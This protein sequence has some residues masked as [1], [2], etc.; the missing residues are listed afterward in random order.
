MSTTVKACWLKDSQGNKFAPKTLSS[1]V[2]TSD[3]VTLE[4]EIQ[5]KL[6]TK[7][8]TGHTHSWNNLQDKPFYE[9]EPVE[10]V[11]YEAEGVS[12]TNIYIENMSLIENET[13]T[14]VCNENTYTLV[15]KKDA[16]GSVYIGNTR[17]GNPYGEHTDTGENFYLSTYGDSGNLCFE[18]D[19]SYSIRITY[20]DTSIVELDKKYIPYVVGERVDNKNLIDKSYSEYV[21][22]VGAEIFNN[23]K[24]NIASGEY[25][26]AEGDETYAFG[27][28]S[29]AEGNHS[30]AEG[31]YSHAENSAHAEGNYSHAENS[32]TARGMCSHSEG[33]G[34]IANGEA[35]HAEGCSVLA[36]GKYQHAQ[37]RYNVIDEADKYAHIVGNGDY[38]QQT[39]WKEIRSN[40]HTLDWNG[41]A[42]FQGEVYVGSTSGTNKDEGSKKLSTVGQDTEGTVYTINDASVTAGAGAEIFNDYTNNI[43]SGN[44]S[45]AEGSSNKATNFTA[46]A[47]GWGNEATGMYSHAEGYSNEAT[48]NSA[49]AEGYDTIASSDYSHSEGAYTKATGYSSHAEG[50]TTESSASYTHAEGSYTKATSSNAHAEGNST[51]ASGDYS[52]AEGYSTKAS[53]SSAHAEGYSTEAT[54]QY[55]HAEGYDSV[56][57]G[58]QSHAEGYSTKATNTSAHAEG[59]YTEASGSYSHAEGYYSKAT[60]SSTHAEGYYSEANGEYSHA[61]G[62]RTVTTG[63]G[64]HTEGK[65]TKASGEYSH[66]EGAYTKAAGQHQ[67]VQGR[68]NIEDTTNTYAHIV[69]NGQWSSDDSKRSNAHTVDW[70]GNA[71]FQG[72]VEATALILSSPN[73]TR[74]QI[75]VGDDGVLSATEITIE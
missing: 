60:K 72:T 71:W 41:N 35:S 52:H 4:S 70:D 75:T 20:Y 15:G 30:T 21:G 5:S 19:S 48:G 42:W 28:A 58:Y 9:T 17:I 68:Y 26:H 12:G 10:K 64:S 32:S 33:Q 66:A 29:H 55:S 25:S 51:E 61:E 43:A 18:G 22:G 57:S 49:H 27:Y 67:H 56:A 65:E 36:F 73:G 62:E 7:S 74:F 59:H 44:Y 50:N 6:D 11:F 63:W 40:A 37:G 14:I 3:G 46:H 38:S 24:F 69:G 31:D 23:Y 47:E 53:Q 13:Y 45:H 16:W 8:D 54:G 2:V 34:S 39:G 1:Q